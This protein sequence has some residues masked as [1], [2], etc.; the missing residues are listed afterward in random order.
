MTPPSPIR[1]ILRTTTTGA[2]FQAEL[3]R[4][5]PRKVGNKLLPVGGRTDWHDVDFC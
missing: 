5:D 3:S 2:L 4:R 1:T